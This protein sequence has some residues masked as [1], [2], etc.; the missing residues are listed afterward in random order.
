M[1]V[2]ETT[3]LERRGID[4]SITDAFTKYAVVTAIANKEEEMV[5]AA[6]YKEWFSKLD[7][8]VQIYMDRGK[9]FLNKLSAELFQ[10]LNVS[11]I[12]MS[13]VHLQYN[14]Q[15]EMFNK[16]V[17]KFWQSFFNNTKLN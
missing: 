9:E 10:L 5:A 2:V 15:V 8:P 3:R 12:K 13:P 14:A 16:M 7:I 6:I 11:H 17:K 1:L 4:D